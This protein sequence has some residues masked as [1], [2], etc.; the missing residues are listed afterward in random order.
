MYIC[1]TISG[2]FGFLYFYMEHYRNLMEVLRTPPLQSRGCS[3]L[4]VVYVVVRER[5][6]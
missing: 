1:S 3:K 4:G 5:D 2:R 6:W